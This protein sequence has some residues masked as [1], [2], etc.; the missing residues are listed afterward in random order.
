MSPA[1]FRAWKATV[2]TVARMSTSPHKVLQE[3]KHSKHTRWWVLPSCPHSKGNATS[4][5]DD[6]EGKGCQCEAALL[7]GVLFLYLF[8]VIEIVCGGSS[9]CSGG[10]WLCSF[11]YYRMRTYWFYFL[12]CIFFFS[13]SIFLS[14]ICGII[15]A[16]PMKDRDRIH[17][18]YFV[19]ITNH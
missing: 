12:F 9:V 11:V 7:L 17:F 8:Y 4:R 19:D 18:F 1:G 6:G 3:H 16:R 15:C 5:V 10:K 14:L 13:L 2:G